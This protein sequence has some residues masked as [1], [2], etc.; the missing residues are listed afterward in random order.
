VY[1]RLSP[2]R[3]GPK[4][5]PRA[6]Y[7]HQE[8]RSVHSVGEVRLVFSA[9]KKELKTATPD[10]VKVLMTNDLRLTVRDVIEL[11][12]LRWQIE[13]SHP[14]YPSSCSLYHGSRAA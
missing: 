10:E 2:H 13:I 8:R 9:T 7:A 1:R 12:S 14:D 4:A 3:I 11:Y 5:R 6:Y